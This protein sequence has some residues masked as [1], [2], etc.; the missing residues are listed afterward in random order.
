MAKAAGD[1]DMQGA[2]DTALMVGFEKQNQPEVAIFFGL[3]AV[4]SFSRFAGICQGWIRICRRDSRSRRASTY[5]TLAE[6][7]V[8]AGRLGEAEQVLDLFK[9]QELKDIVRGAL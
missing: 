7:L 8:Q 3:E 9:E 2:I 5:R 6:L 1:P 4:N